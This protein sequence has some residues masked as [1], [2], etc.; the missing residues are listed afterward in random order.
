MLW[1]TRSPVKPGQT[2][3]AHQKGQ[4]DNKATKNEGEAIQ[5]RKNPKIPPGHRAAAT[6]PADPHGQRVTGRGPRPSGTIASEVV[7]QLTSA[8]ARAVA[9]QSAPPK[10]VSVDMLTRKIFRKVGNGV[11]TFKPGGAVTT[12]EYQPGCKAADLEPLL[13][14]AVKDGFIKTASLREGLPVYIFK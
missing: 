14:G 8:A 3:S 12:A 1:S 9:A 13:K 5:E 6:V 11:F 7:K 2:K 10:T 4:T